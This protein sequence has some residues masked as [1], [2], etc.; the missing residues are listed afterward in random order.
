MNDFFR[1]SGVVVDAGHGG[2]GLDQKIMWMTVNISKY[3]N[4]K[5]L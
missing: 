1:M 5:I 2:I 3:K 4:L